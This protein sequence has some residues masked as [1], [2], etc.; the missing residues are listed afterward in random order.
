MLDVLETHMPV[1]GRTILRTC[2]R[3][4][5]V[6][7]GAFDHLCAFPSLLGLGLGGQSNSRV[8]ASIVRGRAGW[9]VGLH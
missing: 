5:K 2:S 8:L 3:L 7:K 9:G 6:G 1:R 4:Q